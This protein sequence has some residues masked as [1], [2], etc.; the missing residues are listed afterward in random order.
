MRWGLGPL[1]IQITSGCKC[2]GGHFA[3]IYGI[4]D[5][6]VIDSRRL[7]HRLRA[8]VLILALFV[9]L[10]VGS[11]LMANDNVHGTESRRTR[12]ARRV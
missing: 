7:K 9:F 10:G 12:P 6:E 3:V 11:T 2:T 1:G 5:W 8:V 4:L